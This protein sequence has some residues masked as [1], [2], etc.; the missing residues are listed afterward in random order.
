MIALGIQLGMKIVDIENTGQQENSQ[1]G[2]HSRQVGRLAAVRDQVRSVFTPAH[3]LNID[4][5]QSATLN[6]Q[7]WMSRSPIR[8]TA[9]W[10]VVAALLALGM[11]ERISSLDLEDFDPIVVAGGS[12]VGC[13]LALCCWSCRSVAP[14]RQRN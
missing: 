9:G 8:P 11:I 2:V 1:F 13:D 6:A 5:S 4:V 12:V 7:F 3:E 10:I 14:E